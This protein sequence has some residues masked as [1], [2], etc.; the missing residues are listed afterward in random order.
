[1]CLVPEEMQSLDQYDVASP[2]NKEPKIE[3]LMRRVVA[4][5][6]R[7]SGEK[8]FKISIGKTCNV[9]H[10]EKVRFCGK[11]QEQ[12]A[13]DDGLLINVCTDCCQCKPVT[14]NYSNIINNNPTR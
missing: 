13:I 4:I 8:E 3:G 2:K 5:G 10:Q 7:K 9:C 11:C 14:I 6:I 1:M 12:V